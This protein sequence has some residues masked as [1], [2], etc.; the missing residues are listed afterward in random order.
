MPVF[1]WNEEEEE[2]N[3][4]SDNGNSDVSKMST[5]ES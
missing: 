1:V 5:F 4:N 3:G 2:E